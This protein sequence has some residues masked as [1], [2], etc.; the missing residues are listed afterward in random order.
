[1]SV[2]QDRVDL[3]ALIHEEFGTETGII[4]T[5]I[6]AGEVIIDGRK[7]EGGDKLLIPRSAL[8]ARVNVSGVE[9]SQGRVVVVNGPDRKWRVKYQ[10]D[11]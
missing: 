9:Q 3:V 7:W 2:L 10:P 8:V 6:Q 11:E 4:R 5:Q 1:M